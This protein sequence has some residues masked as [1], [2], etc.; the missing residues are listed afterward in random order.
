MNASRNVL[1]CKANIEKYIRQKAN[2]YVCSDGE[3]GGGGVSA[4]GWTVRPTGDWGGLK[5]DLY[6]IKTI[7]HSPSK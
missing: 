1:C 5:A 3:C 6:I 7:I 4:T 2:L